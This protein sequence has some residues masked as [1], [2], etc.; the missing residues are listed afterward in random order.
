MEKLALFG[1]PKAK[2]GPYAAGKRFGKPE[3][4]QLRQALD[5]NTLFYAH[6][7]KVKQLTRRFAGMLGVPYA[8]ATSSGTAA[9]HVALGALGVSVGDEVVTSPI[10][11][12]GSLIGILYQN[13][14]PVFADLDAR[15]YNMTA[16]SIEKVITRRTR[17]ILVVHLAGNPAAMGPIMRLAGRRR[18]SVVEDVA[19][20]YCASYRGKPAG[21]FGALGAFS[22][23]DYKHISTGDGG[24]VVTSNPELARRAALFADKGYDRAPGAPRFVEGLAPNYRMTELQGAVGIA[25]LARL[26]GICRRRNSVGSRI[27]RGISGL[28]GLLPPKVTPGGWHSYWFYMM[29]IDPARLACD[30]TTFAKALAAEGVPASAGYTQTCVYNYPVLAERRAYPRHPEC[31]F[32]PPYRQKPIRYH[33]GLCPVAEKILRTAVLVH[34][35]EFWTAADVRETIAAI[36]K[37]ARHFART[38]STVSRRR[39]K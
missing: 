37:V 30:N 10:T 7:R 2:R 4:D 36:A 26:R 1:G 20:S 27:T 32:D 13:A 16:A 38:A 34:L 23:N 12:M 5:Q 35:N 29:R 3:L 9:I 21:T 28:P 6:G 31:P 15:T 14:V 18:I 17:A 11:D 8:V 19:Q 24:V 39:Q 22:L 25:Q 33:E